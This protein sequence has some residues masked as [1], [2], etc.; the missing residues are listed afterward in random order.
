MRTLRQNQRSGAWPWLKQP[1]LTAVA[2][3]TLALGACANTVISIVIAKNPPEMAQAIAQRLPLLAMM[4]KV[5]LFIA[6][7]SAAVLLLARGAARERDLAARVASGVGRGGSRAPLLIEGALV[8][9]A[10]GGGGALLAQWALYVLQALSPPA[11]TQ[12]NQIKIDARELGSALLTT[13]IVG[14]L[15]GLLLVWQASRIKRSPNDGA[16]AGRQ[17]NRALNHACG[18][19]VILATA[20]ALTL[21]TCGGLLAKS[22]AH[23]RM[24]DPGFI[25]DDRMIVATAL[26]ADKYGSPEKRK[27]FFNQLLER[28]RELP[29]AQITDLGSEAPLSDNNYFALLFIADGWRAPGAREGRFPIHRFVNPEYFKSAGIELTQGR[30]FTAQDTGAAAPVVIINEAMARRYWPDASPVGRRLV[31]LDE[32]VSREIVGVIRNDGASTHSAAGQSEIFLPD[33]QASLPPRFISVR[34]DAVLGSVASE[35]HEAVKAIDRGIHVRDISPRLPDLLAP[36]RFKLI[37]FGAIGVLA[38]LLTPVGLYGLTAYI[39][40]QSASASGFQAPGE[41][42]FLDVRKLIMSQGLKLAMVGIII[43]LG[44]SFA[45]SRVLGGMLYGVSLTDPLTFALMAALLGA[46]LMLACYM[47]ARRATKVY[48]VA[49]LKRD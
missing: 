29:G 44:F 3:I 49:A 25:V 38:L 32:K 10:G 11:W 8:G 45:M 5:V 28:L 23:W 35:T 30:I 26:R 14:L 34:A 20:L 1:G 36:E 9:L 12:F 13:V 15:F 33:S 24:V 27:I 48:P 18:A 21:M 42:P 43:G 41:A 19:L 37:L 46:A 47:Q 17:M 31:A 39:G 6:C 22:F 40:A 16:G 4:G 7:V 2:I